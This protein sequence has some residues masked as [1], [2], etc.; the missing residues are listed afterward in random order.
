M[1]EKQTAKLLDDWY[2]S[3]LGSALLE[4]EEEQLELVLPSLF[5]YSLLQIGLPSQHR[6]LS[7][8]PIAHKIFM[9]SADYSP[10]DVSIIADDN[11][12]PFPEGSLDLVLLPHTLEFTDHPTQTIK[13]C[14]RILLPE[15]HLL[16]FAFNPYSLWGLKRLFS[17]RKQSFP[18]TG[19]FFSFSRLK[20]WLDAESFQICHYQTFFY[21]PPFEEQKCLEK[22]FFLE[23]LGKLIWPYPGGI[24]MVIAR[25]KVAGMTPI[26][27]HLKLHS[28]Q[29]DF[30]QGTASACNCAP[31]S[32][33][34]EN[35]SAME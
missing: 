10:K 20:K 23:T 14:A 29:L 8:S 21:R 3:V 28:Q 16:I 27:P 2:Q 22:S 19:N 31:C 4:M 24:Y 1:I 11:F 25:H 30:R 6:W 13:E 5:G 34:V 32:N 17:K 9:G 18:W 33:K 26:R 7:K 12:L 35:S 15:G